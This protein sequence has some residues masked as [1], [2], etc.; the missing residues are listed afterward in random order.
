MF[1]FWKSVARPED[2][3]GRPH[4]PPGPPRPVVPKKRTR[5]VD[6]PGLIRQA[7]QKIR[8]KELLRMGKKDITLLSREKI[9]DLINR[10]VKAAVEKLGVKGVVSD[11][12]L[13]RIQSD[14]RVQFAELL[15]KAKFTANVS[16]DPTRDL[17][18]LIKSFTTHVP[19]PKRPR[20]DIQG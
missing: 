7:S 19:D 9:E 18:K 15:R 10:S 5:V 20:V 13:A 2:R 1:S 6:V 16:D 3:P 14:S 12:D 11:A 17:L 4:V 8:I